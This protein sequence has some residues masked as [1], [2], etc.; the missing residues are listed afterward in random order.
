MSVNTHIK[1][2]FICNSFR[3]YLSLFSLILNVVIAYDLHHG[4]CHGPRSVSV[5]LNTAN[6]SALRLWITLSYYRYRES[7]DIATKPDSR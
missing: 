2:K 5:Q 1:I 3:N 4:F 7:P 6:G